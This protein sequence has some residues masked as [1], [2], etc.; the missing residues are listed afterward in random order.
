MTEKIPPVL[1]QIRDIIEREYATPPI[2]SGKYWEERA[3]AGIAELLELLIQQAKRE[4]F[5]DIDRERFG[6]PQHIP[7]AG[8]ELV[9]V[10]LTE[11]TLQY[12]KDKHL[13]G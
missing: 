1:N 7:E 5:E 10:A 2:V 11:T 3:T 4:I 12:I 13:K 8:R 6:E 9:V